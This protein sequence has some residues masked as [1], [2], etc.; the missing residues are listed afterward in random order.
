MGCSVFTRPSIIS[1]KPVTFS[2]GVTSTPASA[3]AFGGAARADYFDA[4]LRQIL[5]EINDAGFVRHANQSRLDFHVHLMSP[6]QN[7]TR[8]FTARLLGR[9]DTRQPTVCV[10]D[11]HFRVA[12]ICCVFHGSSE[13]HR[14]KL[15]PFCIIHLYQKSRP[16]NDER[17]IA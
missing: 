9:L 17:F 2:M 15:F 10:S 16:G 5:G 13:V 8:I 6:F 14:I 1:G 11:I 12:Q 3:S 4:H 7:H